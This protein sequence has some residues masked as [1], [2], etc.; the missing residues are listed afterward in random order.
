MRPL[1]QFSAAL[2]LVVAATG[3]SG[4]SSSDD[5]GRVALKLS[6]TPVGSST[7]SLL[8]PG[9]SITLGADVILIENVELVARKIKL[10]RVNGSCPAPVTGETSGTDADESGTDECPNLRLGPLLIAPPLT[11][12]VSSSFTTDIPVGTYDKMMLQIHKPAGSKDAAFMAANPDFNG[13][14]IRVTGT[15]NTIPFTFTTSLTSVVEIA[16]PEVIEVDGEGVT[17]LTLKVD[18]RNW[19]LADGGASLINPLNLTQQNRSR[20]EQAIRASFKVFEDEDQDG[21]D[22]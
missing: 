13:V 21:I 11:A 22:D 1:Y 4:T 16:F 6:T 2:A 9:L 8:A 20:I 5:T 18:V 3:C 17:A 19:F 10:Q 12:G 14:S 7:A 15:F